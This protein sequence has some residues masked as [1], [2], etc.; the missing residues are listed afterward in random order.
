M[1]LSDNIYI[2]FILKKY[3]PE[4]VK[5]HKFNQVR[6]WRF[7]YAI[8]NHKI[9]IEFEGAVW[10]NGR[11]T[12]GRGYIKDIEKYNAAIFDGWTLIRFSYEHIKT[13]YFENTIKQLKEGINEN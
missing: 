3:F 5:E 8:V 12:R 6:K 4:F 13:P 2:E 1:K 7:D 11:H 9:G 10:A